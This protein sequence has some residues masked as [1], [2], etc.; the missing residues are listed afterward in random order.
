MEWPSVC[1]LLDCCCSTPLCRWNGSACANVVNAMNIYSVCQ[2]LIF[3]PLPSYIAVETPSVQTNTNIWLRGEWHRHQYLQLHLLWTFFKD[4]CRQAKNAFFSYVT[5]P[6]NAFNVS[7]RISF[8]ERNQMNVHAHS[9]RLTA[10]DVSR[11]MSFF[12][13]ILLLLD[14]W[15]H[16]QTLMRRQTSKLH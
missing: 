11:K 13:R 5:R 6:N 16:A 2:L 15:I 8:C 1:I 4:R 3:F 10:A 9:C 7:Y 14:K 12:I